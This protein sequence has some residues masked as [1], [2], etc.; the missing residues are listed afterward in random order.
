M[1]S[2]SVDRALQRARG[3]LTPDPSARARVLGRLEMRFPELADGAGAELESSATLGRSRPDAARGGASRP[4]LWRAIRAT[5]AGGAALGTG[6]V[7]AGFIA[8]YAT[9][10]PPQAPREP[11]HASAVAPVTASSSA[12]GEPL[13]DRTPPHSASDRTGSAPNGSEE[14]AVK[15][16]NAGRDGRA[17]SPAPKQTSALETAGPNPRSQLEHELFVLQRAERALRNDNAELALALL[18]QLDAEHPRALL[19]EERSATRLMASCQA[20]KDGAARAAHMFLERHTR[21]VYGDRLRAA[22]QLETDPEKSAG[23]ATDAAARDID[24]R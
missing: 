9:R 17:R 4:G 24:G 8:G 19:G 2:S 20:G 10:T 3:A 12:A 6:L 21:S 13:A 22:C 1:N 5:G 11:G 23:A 15:D 16:G 18:A 7:M 14:D